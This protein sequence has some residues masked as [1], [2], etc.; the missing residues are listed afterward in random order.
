MNTAAI[1]GDDAAQAPRAAGTEMIFLGNAD[2]VGSYEWVPT[3]VR[4]GTTPLPIYPS[5]QDL[6]AIGERA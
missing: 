2:L 6:R 5:P 1:Y 3:E 4:P